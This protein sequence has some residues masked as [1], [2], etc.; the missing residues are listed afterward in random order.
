MLF[1]LSVNYTPKGLEAMGKNPKTN[2][3]EAV[4]KL[5]NAAGGKMVSM[6]A[7]IADGPGAMVIFDIDPAVAPA[8][9]AVAASSDAVQHQD[10][11]PLHNRRDDGYP[12]EEGRTA[13]CL[14]GTGPVKLAPRGRPNWR[15]RHLS[16]VIDG[17]APEGAALGKA[18]GPGCDAGCSRSTHGPETSPAPRGAATGEPRPYIS[19]HAP[20]AR[21]TAADETWRIKVLALRVGDDA[22]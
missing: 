19:A 15:P 12:R 7:T 9:A 1:C 22:V 18:R 5:L 10:A 3:R 6:Y 21:H 2:R 8:I 4:E 11:A 14:R 13:S 16:T 17:H 20:P